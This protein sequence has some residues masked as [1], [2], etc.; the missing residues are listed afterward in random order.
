MGPKGDKG[1]EG[2]PGEPG[3]LG[4]N[5]FFADYFTATTLNNSIFIK[6]SL[7]CVFIVIYALTNHDHPPA[8]ALPDG[9][10]VSEN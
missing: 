4:K 8:P 7:P 9:I 3:T 6:V 10:V 5:C 1:D 2:M